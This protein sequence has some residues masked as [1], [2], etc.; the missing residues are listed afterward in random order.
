M[1]QFGIDKEESDFDSFFEY[2]KTFRTNPLS[3]PE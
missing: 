2:E 3:I 1:K